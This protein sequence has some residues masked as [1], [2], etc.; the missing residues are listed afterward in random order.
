MAKAKRQA[1][2]TK[3]RAAVNK[4]VPTGPKPWAELPLRDRLE[5]ARQEVRR[6]QAEVAELR[7]SLR[8]LNAHGHLQDGK[9]ACP[10]EAVAVLPAGRLTDQGY[11]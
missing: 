3:A 10:L 1:A 7:V 9:L 2:K 6:L 8:L 4:S 5:R 11:F